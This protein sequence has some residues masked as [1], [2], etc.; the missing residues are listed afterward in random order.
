MQKRIIIT[1]IGVIT[2]PSPTVKSEIREKG[3]IEVL[4]AD[5]RRYFPDFK[6]DAKEPMVTVTVEDVPKNPI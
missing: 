1:V 2:I 4:S 3:F 6:P 5:L